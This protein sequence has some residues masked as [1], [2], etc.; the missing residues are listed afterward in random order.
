MDKGR[1]MDRR[2][3]YARLHIA[4]QKAGISEE[5]YRAILEER[6]GV[7]SAKAL[8]DAEILILLNSFT[9]QT[10]AASPGCKGDHGQ[11]SC[12]QWRMIQALRR[13]LGWTE[14]ELEKYIKKYGHVD[15]RRFLTVPRARAVINGLIGIEK[16]Q[17]AKG[18]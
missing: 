12:K 10:K 11:A 18:Y 15:S 1:G 16:W 7:S 2:K 9:A 13:N 6:F 3:L 8:S 4:R 5:D 14:E 17:K